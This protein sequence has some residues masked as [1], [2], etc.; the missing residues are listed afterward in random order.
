MRFTCSHCGKAYA[1]TEHLKRHIQSTHHSTE[2]DEA[3]RIFICDAPGCQKT[4]RRSD[5]LAR[6]KRGHATSDN[7]PMPKKIK[8]SDSTS[9]PVDQAPAT[10]QYVETGTYLSPR[11][12]S[13]QSPSETAHV[14]PQVIANGCF[15]QTNGLAGGAVQPVQQPVQPLTEQALQQQQLAALDVSLATRTSGMDAEYLPDSALY[16]SSGISFSFDDWNTQVFGQQDGGRLGWDSLNYKN[17]TGLDW[18]F[19]DGAASL[20][21]ASV[22]SGAMPSTFEEDFAAALDDIGPKPPDSLSRANEKLFERAKGYGGEADPFESLGLIN[23]ANT[24]IDQANGTGG[25]STSA[26]ARTGRNPDDDGEWPQDFR[27]TRRQPPTLEISDYILAVEMEDDMDDQSAQRNFESSESFSEQ[28]SNR[29]IPLVLIEEYPGDEATASRSKNRSSPTAHARHSETSDPAY[30]ITGKAR[31]NLLEYLRHSCK[32]PWSVYSFNGNADRFLLTSELEILLSLY[33]KKVH[34]YTPILHAASFDPETASPVLLLILITKGLVFYVSEM[35]ARG[36]RTS[37]LTRL[38]KR[39]N[40]LGPAFSESTRI[41]T[42]SAYEADQRGFLDVSINQAWL[43]QQM[44][45]IGSGNK[46][47]YKLAERNRGGI[48]T[49]IRRTGLLNMPGLRLD[50]SEQPLESIDEQLLERRWRAW[51]DRESRIRLAWFVFLYDQLYGLYM[52]ISPMLLYTEVTSPFP[53][54]E[55]LWNAKSAREW[56]LRI[57]QHTQSTPKASFIDVLRKLLD[58]P[59]HEDIPLRLNRL[60]AYILSVTLYRIRWDTSKRSVLFGMEAFAHAEQV[61]LGENHV[62]DAASGTVAIDAAAANALQG[63]AEAASYATASLTGSSTSNRSGNLARHSN[64]ALSIDVQL[65]RFLSKMHFSGP[66]AFFDRLKDAAG[67]AGTARRTDAVAELR[68]WVVDPKNHVA[69]RGML[70]ASA[71]VYDLVRNCFEAMRPDAVVL[72]SHVCIVSLFHAALIL[73]AYDKLRPHQHEP[74]TALHRNGPLDH[75]ASELLKARNGSADDILKLSRSQAEALPYLSPAALRTVEESGYI[76][77]VRSGSDVSQGT[78]SADDWHERSSEGTNGSNSSSISDSTVSSRVVEAWSMGA[79]RSTLDG[80]PRRWNAASHLIVRVA[81]IGELR[82]ARKD[83]STTAQIASEGSSDA[84]G[85]VE[86]EMKGSGPTTPS[87]MRGS[88]ETPFLPDSGR[89]RSVRTSQIL[90]RFASLLRKLDWG[91]AASFR[92][93][94]VHMARQEAKAAEAVDQRVPVEA[95]LKTTV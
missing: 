72:Q 29:H 13:Q 71:Q 83:A 85:E 37:S 31:L 3:P 23:L 88:K 62:V 25:P 21:D 36:A 56:Y 54:D 58:P 79:Y 28:G 18:I 73:W 8:R 47:L 78:E 90:L 1:R 66:P 74:V 35:Q 17:L 76:D 75:A 80:K 41:G 51:I 38:Q 45:G 44:F 7:G 60:E 89:A 42:M 48:M 50:F 57:P 92:T 34:P 81:G 2:A 69:M 6:H 5:V 46:R 53:C 40:T 63:L 49:A 39:V 15:A 14:H 91:L 24:A 10:L 86:N 30:Q 70:L 33:F 27:P 32:H 59:R 9:S 95:Q 55:Q 11:G 68:R 61:T 67:R 19:D 77:L 26:A 43:L 4:F 82:T 12:A 64:I 94:L 93:I 16:G 20:T 65:L 22:L 87:K 84:G 52:D